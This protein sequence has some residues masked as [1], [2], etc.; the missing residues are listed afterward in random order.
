[1]RSSIPDPRVK[2]GV[3]QVD[4]KIHRDVSE[5]NKR[6]RELI[7]KDAPKDRVKMIDAELTRRMKILNDRAR[8]LEK[9]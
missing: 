9:N 3:Q 7:K 1:L 6:K 5:L 2:Q 8:Q 4:E